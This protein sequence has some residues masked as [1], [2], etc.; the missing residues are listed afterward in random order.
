M[1]APVGGPKR[2]VAE[3]PPPAML[4]PQIG[5]RPVTNGRNMATQ[6]ALDRAKRS[7]LRPAGMAAEATSNTVKKAR[8]RRAGMSS[9]RG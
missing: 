3:Y 5:R 9:R 4:R 6:E 8:R 7:S 1:G 2:G